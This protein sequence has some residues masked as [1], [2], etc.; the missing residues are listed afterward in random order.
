MGVILEAIKKGF[1]VASKNLG[2]V[3]ILVVFNLAG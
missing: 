2:L 3:L 1:G